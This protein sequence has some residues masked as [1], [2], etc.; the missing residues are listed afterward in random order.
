[1]IPDYHLH[2]RF[3]GDCET[4]VEQLITTARSLGMDSIC[5]TDHNDL[6]FPKTPDDVTF[7]LDIDNYMSYL[8]ELKL[9][10]QSPDFLQ[11]DIVPFSL[12]IGLEQGVMPST[13]EKLNTYSKDH[14]GLDFII[15][16]THVVDDMDPYYKEYFE[17]RD[18]KEA[19]TRYFESMLYNTEHFDDYNVYGHIDY[20]LRYGPSKADHFRDWKFI[21]IIEA[22][23]KNIIYNGKGIEINTGS[24]YRGLSYMHPH[25][26]ILKLYRE[27]GGEII[28]VGS[29]AHD[30]THVG[31]AFD[32]AAKRLRQF[33]F[34]FYCTFRDMK[35]TFVPIEM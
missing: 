23:F 3:S 32:E 13:C 21:E 30:L 18:E 22:A 29:D 11:D 25:D 34:R 1:M 17:G 35:P 8:K 16:S 26:D 24:L 28:T 4:D 20:I 19:Y 15:C 6:D 5:I 12:R 33:G 2:T 7:D 14:P 10:F 31:Y 27:M 9:K